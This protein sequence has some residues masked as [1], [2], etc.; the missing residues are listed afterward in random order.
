MASAL[1]ALQ[2]P[3]RFGSKCSARFQKRV[4]EIQILANLSQICNPTFSWPSFTGSIERYS[5]NRN[6]RRGLNLFRPAS[7]LSVS[8][9]LKTRDGSKSSNE[10]SRSERLQTEWTPEPKKSGRRVN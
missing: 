1:R 10:R 3:L 5:K 8:R 6:V 7:I 4:D 2:W 9:A